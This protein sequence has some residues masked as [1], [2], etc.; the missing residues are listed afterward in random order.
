VTA[1]NSQTESKQ[2]PSS[3][4][5][6]SEKKGGNGQ[7]EELASFVFTSDRS[8]PLMPLIPTA[9][10]GEADGELSQLRRFHFGVA[11][12]GQSAA[13]VSGMIPAQLF[14]Y[15]D[16]E[17]IRHDYPLLL[18]AGE[19]AEHPPICRPV[20]DFLKA[21]IA[22]FA[23]EES[24]SRVLK[25]NLP[26][27]ELHIRGALAGAKGPVSADKVFGE[28][29]KKVIEELGLNSEISAQLS[30]DFG[31]ISE[32]LPGAAEFLGFDGHAAFHLF[33]FSAAAH[34]L[35]RRKSFA[36][37]LNALRGQ[38]NGLL[39][40]EK[41]KSG[42]ANSPA[43]LKSTLGKFSDTH[44]DASALSNLV[45]EHRGTAAMSGD[46]RERIENT[47]SRLEGFE[48]RLA[49]KIMTVLHDGYLP[50]ADLRNQSLRLVRNRNPFG[51]AAKVYEEEVASWLDVFRAMRVARLDIDNAYEP[52][53]HDDWVAALDWRSLSKEEKELVPIVVV[54]QQ[55]ARFNAQSVSELSQVLLGGQP[56]KVLL[57]V[58]PAANPLSDKDPLGGYRLEL[59]YLA[60]S[61]RQ[62]V[63]QQ[64]AAA[65]PTHM[66][67]GL[68]E[69]MRV[70]RPAVHLVASGLTLGGG[71]GPL[72][73]W[74]QASAALEG[75]AHP[76]FFFNPELG[77]SRADSFDFRLNPQPEE[78]WPVYPLNY[79]T[80]GE[81][82]AS[83]N[84]PFTFADYA[85]LD[86]AFH[87]HFRRVSEQVDTADLIPLAEYLD[88]DQEEVGGQIPFTWALDSKLQMVRLALSRSLATACADRMAY[89][90]NLQELA[91][92][93][94]AYVQAARQLAEEEA[95]VA[96]VAERE[97]LTLEHEDVVEKVRVEE[98][99]T[100]ME[101]LAAALLKADL[102]A[103][104][105]GASAAASKLVA[106]A[107]AM[108]PADATETAEPAAAVEVAQEAPEE[109]EAEEPWIDTA[110]C[111]SC[112]DC[113]DINAQLFSYDGNKQAVM[114]DP[115]AGTF[116]QLV[117]AA[118]KCPARCIHP[119]A[120]VN[121]DEPEL[122]A[123]VKRAE[124]FN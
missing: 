58:E 35:H 47:L 124:P 59:G 123:L 51:A 110:L 81:E 32:Q 27:F 4:P 1:T 74:L 23:A 3:K 88:S 57:L 111:T 105:G 117:A 38:L 116:A 11:H 31:R 83:M 64:T 52:A 45:G 118:E 76:F 61:H 95:A 20:G 53:R 112:N 26:R 18:A 119:G 16:P 65:H 48:E 8:L 6:A 15:R 68:S 122:E 7:S 114:G 56:I 25:D 92:V 36:L 90:R 70:A 24:Q 63:V 19:S 115:K 46:R 85:L 120:P 67:E 87:L 104:P 106:P 103:L 37:T 66:V 5:V 21:A 17:K 55:T 72:G 84:L 22:E 12:E 99:S 97:R 71:E 91:G 80:E 77:A 107:E 62:A 13:S 14:P 96:L 75:R 49:G 109:E 94:N 2:S 89:W 10:D 73:R 86:P 41:G 33:K 60:L 102:S 29:S 28:M 82:S 34:T 43:G 93:K 78:K 42:E 44:F 54:V 40:V 101:K 100:V 121:P 113:I 79:S 39:A 108:A 50:E 30:E 9:T 69:A 98:A